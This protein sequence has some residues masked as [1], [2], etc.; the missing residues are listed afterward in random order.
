MLRNALL[1]AKDAL[2]SPDARKAELIL[3]RLVIAAVA[4]QLGLD[5]S[6]WVS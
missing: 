6:Q 4:A 1:A 5:I 2:L 3:L